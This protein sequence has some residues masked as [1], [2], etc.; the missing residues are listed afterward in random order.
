MCGRS[1]QESDS[2]LDDGKPFSSADS[3]LFVVHKPPE[4]QD[5]K[6]A[7]NSNLI[8]PIGLKNLPNA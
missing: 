8:Q 2:L 4:V 5:S 7:K 1:L 6:C 3:S